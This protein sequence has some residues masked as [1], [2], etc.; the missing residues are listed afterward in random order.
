MSVTR[1]MRWS[2]VA[3]LAMI[4]VG[5][6]TVGSD[7]ATDRVDQIRIGETTREQVR[8]MFGEPWRTGIEDGKPTW[9]YGKYRWSAFSDAQTTD[10]VIRFDDQGRVSSYVYNTTE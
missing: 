1:M 6:A 8:D 2:M 5:C 4:M 3:L 9:T 7:F 10:L